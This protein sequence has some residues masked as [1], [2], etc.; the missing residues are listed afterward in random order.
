MGKIR[1]YVGNNKGK[2]GKIMEM[3]EGFKTKVEE[4]K[5]MSGGNS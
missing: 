3:S 5:E 1:R 4:N 2:V